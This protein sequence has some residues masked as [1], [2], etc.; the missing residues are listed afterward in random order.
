MLAIGDWRLPH[1]LSELQRLCSKIVPDDW[2]EINIVGNIKLKDLN[3]LQAIDDRVKLHGYVHDISLY[4]EKSG[5]WLIGAGSGSGIP[6][7]LIEA[8]LYADQ[9]I[10]SEYCKNLID[11]CDLN[12]R[13]IRV[14]VL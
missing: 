3:K 13:K 10:C 5:T 7:K 1:N 4:M 12:A 14:K 11:H 2:D 8:C 6:I 9:I